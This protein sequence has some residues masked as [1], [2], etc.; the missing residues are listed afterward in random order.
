MQQWLQCIALELHWCVEQQAHVS[1][2]GWLKCAA[3]YQPH[4]AHVGKL[5]LYVCE[6]AFLFDVAAE[7]YSTSE[8]GHQQYLSSKMSILEKK[9]ELYQLSKT[10]RVDSRLS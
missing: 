5:W 7:H 10:H 4:R 8:G 9:Q 6:L 2:Y 3:S 1:L